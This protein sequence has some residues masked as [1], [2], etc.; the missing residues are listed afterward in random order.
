MFVVNSQ[1]AG[2]RLDK[3]LAQYFKA[4]SLSRAKIQKLIKAGQIT[5]NNKPTSA[6]YQLKAGDKVR[7]ERPSPLSTHQPSKPIDLSHLIVA[8]EEEFLVVN[9]P[10]GLLVHLAE[11]LSGPALTDSLL[12]YCPAIKEVGDDCW[13][14][15][16]VHR[17]DKD[18]SGLLVVAKT[19]NAFNWLKEQFKAR[20][21]KKKYWVLAYGKLAQETGEISFPLQRSA[22]G[23]KIAALPLKV[24]GEKNLAGRDAVTEFR[25]KQRWHN[26]TLL[27]VTIKT[28]R[29]H[30]IRAHLAALG[31]PVIGDNLYGNKKSKLANQ[32]LEINRLFLMAYFLAFRGLDGKIREYQIEL[33]PELK[34]ILKKLK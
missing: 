34:A 2:E 24:K 21:V 16:I 29:T 22:A 20:Q 32:K 17:L 14:P 6:H 31:H 10:A 5:V 4:E 7:I 23:Y 19:Q 18:A 15:G 28:G 1:Q 33:P 12:A 8:E 30:Q 9:K 11:S 27:E 3:F 25:V 13:R 26:F